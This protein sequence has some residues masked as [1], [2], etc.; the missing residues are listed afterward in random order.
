MFA[1]AHLQVDNERA[2][3]TEWRFAPGAGETGTMHGQDYVVADD[4]QLWLVEP[5]RARSVLQQAGASYA[6]PAGGNVIKRQRLRV[7]GLW[8]S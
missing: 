8:K 4:G 3:V 7:P 5:R 6:R 1:T 2:I